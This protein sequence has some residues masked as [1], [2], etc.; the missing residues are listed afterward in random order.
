MI[1]ELEI[2]GARLVISGDNLAVSVTDA[3]RP[4]VCRSTEQQSGADI[5]NNWFKAVRGRQAAL[6]EALGIT[7]AAIPQW[8]EVPA[9][10]LVSVERITGIDRR[11]LRPDLFEGM[12]ES[13][14]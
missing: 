7:R 4:S 13:P 2:N 10:K 8:H 6:A 9:D 14:S 12:S 3:D 1:V 5:L 11:V